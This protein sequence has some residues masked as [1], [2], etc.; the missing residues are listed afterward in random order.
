MKESPNESPPTP[1]ANAVVN[2]ELA[3]NPSTSHPNPILTADGPSPHLSLNGNE[4]ANAQT[5]DCTKILEALIFF[6]PNPLKVSSIRE[7][8]QA[9]QQAEPNHPSAAQA[10][11]LTEEKILDSILQICREYEESG[12]PFLLVETASG[13]RFVSRP[14]FAPWLRKL[15][16]VEQRPARLSAAALETLAIIA[17][18]QPISR[19]E[20]E[21]VRGVN[22]DR[23]L[24]SL[25]ERGLVHITG[26]STAPGRPLLYGTTQAFLEHFGIRSLE[27]LPNCEEFRQVPLHLPEQ[28]VVEP[29]TPSVHDE[30]NSRNET[31]I[32]KRHRNSISEPS[33]QL[34]LP[35]SADIGGEDSATD[36]K[37]ESFPQEGSR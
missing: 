16:N 10:A 12:R 21:A 5:L 4:S 30:E 13:W 25:V 29:A 19:A 17:Y 32:S 20:I 3:A 8:L 22:V 26:R 35:T 28:P 34:V 23:A 7:I 6:S 33:P 36:S 27:E 18:R 31:N 24:Q 2:P 9:V 14:E 11:Q 1:T 15:L 37:G